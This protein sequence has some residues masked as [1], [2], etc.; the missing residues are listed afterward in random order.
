MVEEFEILR[1]MTTSPVGLFLVGV[2]VVGVLLEIVVR[3]LYKSVKTHNKPIGTVFFH[4]I[5]GQALFFTA[6]AIGAIVTMLYIEPDY[7]S[8]GQMTLKILGAC[9]TLDVTII[10]FTRLV[11]GWVSIYMQQKNY[12]AVSIV[13]NTI[14]TLVATMAIALSLY[15][16]GVPITPWLTLIAG[17][18]LGISFALKDPL[19][20]LF[21]GIM[22]V[23]S[24]R[25]QPNDY[26]KLASGEEG[27]VTDIKWHTATIRQLDNNLVIIPNSALA[28]AVVIN[29]DQPEREMSILVNLGVAYTSD[30]EHVERVTIEVADEIMQEVAGGVE[31][32]SSFIRYNT[33]ADFSINFTVIMRGQSFVD[34]Y[35]IKHEFV[36]RLHARYNKEGIVIPFPIRTLETN[37]GNPL[38]FTNGE[39]MPQ[40]PAQQPAQQLQEP[41]SPR[42]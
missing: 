9:V 35:L 33:F 16:F 29:Y 41:T 23:I 25:I 24:N 26:I 10:I 12:P 38:A 42:D 7:P 34:Q 6:M 40:Q 3:W 13:S 11:R 37:P 32:S 15:S 30:L 31:T 14:S 36:K 2:L 18:S 4:A 17:S 8:V 39:A 27:Y 1:A 5:K 19:A 28:T 22:L 20:N 21:S